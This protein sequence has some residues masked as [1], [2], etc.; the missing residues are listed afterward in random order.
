MESVDWDR[1]E[2]DPLAEE[3]RASRGGPDGERTIWA[4]E[5]ALHAARVDQQLLEYLL[6]ATVCLLAR[7]EGCSPRTVLETFFRRSV[8]DETWRERF[9]PLFE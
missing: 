8:P 2:L 1:F 7:A 5:Q 3:I 9:L 4:L 6:S